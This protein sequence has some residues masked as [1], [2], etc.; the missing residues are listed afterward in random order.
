MNPTQ[1][2]L[3]ESQGWP[4]R[5]WHPVFW[6]STWFGIGLLR[7][8]PGS[9][10]SLAALPVAYMLALAGGAM[11]LAG[12]AFALFFVGLWASGRYGMMTARSDAPEV[13]IDEV[14]GQWLALLPVVAWACANPWLWA[15]AFVLFRLF[16]IAKPWPIG[17]LD[18][19]L[20]GG[21]GVMADDAV[22]GMATALVLIAL[23][24]SG[25]VAL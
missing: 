23:M 10:G 17:W 3:P 20:K 24:Q 5:P 7:P 18:R 13:V 15:A 25:L 16:D 2:P 12:A 19:E 9:W 21:L 11:A 22:A 14:V 8:A 1:Q 6:L 4:K